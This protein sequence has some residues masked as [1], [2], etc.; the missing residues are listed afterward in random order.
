[1]FKQKSEVARCVEGSEQHVKWPLRS[2]PRRFMKEGRRP[3]P[4]RPG[5]QDQ[6]C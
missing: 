5:I 4:E 2:C 6:P 3:G 1:M